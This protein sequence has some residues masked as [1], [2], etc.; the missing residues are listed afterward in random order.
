MIILHR[1]IVVLALLKCSLTSATIDGKELLQVSIVTK[2]GQR[3]PEWLFPKDPYKAAVHWPEG[4][5]QLT[6]EGSKQMK[7]LGEILRKRYTLF[8]PLRY[9][10]A[11][12]FIA[13]T[14]TNETIYSAAALAS[15]LY[16]NQSVPVIVTPI[17]CDHILN[18]K[19]NCPAYDEE[20]ANI[21]TFRD[22]IEDEKK[23]LA[24]YRWLSPRLGKQVTSL[25]A[26]EILYTNL[27]IENQRGLELPAWT[28]DV[29]LEP[30]KTLAG[31]YLSKFSYT[32]TAQ[33][34]KFGPLLLEILNH[35]S[36]AG[37]GK[38]RRLNVYSAHDITLVGLLKALELYENVPPGFAAALVFEVHRNGTSQDR[39]IRIFYKKDDVSDLIRVDVPECGIPC[40]LNKL[41]GILSAVLPMNITTECMSKKS[42]DDVPPVKPDTDSSGGFSI[43]YVAICSMTLAITGVLII[44]TMKLITCNNIRLRRTQYTRIDGN[45]VS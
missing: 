28:K 45:D 4:W 40:T 2:H 13:S 26:I 15:G 38:Y 7:V 10:G 5:S 8:F 34:L 31:I 29:F 11:D 3:T 18:L 24:L 37:I 32:T 36:T 39:E 35:A 44:W 27:L 21:D 6:S 43:Y 1:I 41:W 42:H 14:D 30:L 19:S 16:P 17:N 22:I 20:L 9:E 12:T 33:R 25:Q 23:H